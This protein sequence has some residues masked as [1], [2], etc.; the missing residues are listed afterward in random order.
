MAESLSFLP[1]L[2]AMGSKITLIGMSGLGKSH[3]SRLLGEKGFKRFCCDDLIAQRLFNTCDQ[4]D[5]KV[6]CLGLW[7]G[8]PFAPGYKEREGAYC[9]AEAGILAELVAYLE[10]SNPDEKVVID[11]TGSAPYAGEALMKRLSG[12]TRMVHLAASTAYV[13]VMAKNYER[14]PRPVVWGD[15][16]HRNPGETEKEALTRCYKALLTYRETLYQKYAHQSIP[17]QLHR[18]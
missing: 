1:V 3:W 2:M 18:G 11:T 9:L 14:S 10:G 13:D 5:S 4:A 16:Y 17:Y 12:L 7:M 8:F 15:M 6:E